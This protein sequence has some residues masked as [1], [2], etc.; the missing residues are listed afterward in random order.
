MNIL[1]VLRSCEAI[2]LEETVR[3]LIR[4][5]IENLPK[6]RRLD[7]QDTFRLWRAF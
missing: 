6:G 7:I 2:V 4:I 3:L 1:I 5:M